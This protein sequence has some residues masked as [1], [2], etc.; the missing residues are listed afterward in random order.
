MDIHR[1]IQNIL[2][3]ILFIFMNTCSYIY[4]HTVLTK[5]TCRSGNFKT[6]A[7]YISHITGKGRIIVEDAVHIGQRKSNRTSVCWVLKN[8][9]KYGFL[10][11]I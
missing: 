2:E 4:I 5:V 9:F 6:F 7:W 1:T 11:E 10:K 8:S 3:Y